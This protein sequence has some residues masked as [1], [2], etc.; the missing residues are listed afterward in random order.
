MASFQ[1]PGPI[2]AVAAP[3]IIGFEDTPL[4]TI[5]IPKQGPKKAYFRPLWTLLWDGGV[6]SL[7]FLWKTYLIYQL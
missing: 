4:Y 3:R 6:V 5:P 7:E 1:L 2:A